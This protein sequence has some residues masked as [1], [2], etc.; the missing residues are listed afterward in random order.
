[1]SYFPYFQEKHQLLPP[2]IWAVIYYLVILS[3][4]LLS[5]WLFLPCCF[6]PIVAINNKDTFKFPFLQKLN[7]NN[8]RKLVYITVIYHK[9]LT[10]TT[11]LL[12][13]CMI[14]SA[15]MEPR[16]ISCADSA[17]MIFLNSA[18]FGIFP[19]LNSGDF[20]D[21]RLKSY[22][23]S[24]NVI[25]FGIYS[26]FALWKNICMHLQTP[27]NVCCNGECVFELGFVTSQS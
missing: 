22:I 14:N 21:F 8:L 2:F 11:E 15:S 23:P 26:F 7:L 24:E 12:F 6:D 1:M 3:H 27:R 5:L 25:V 13:R 18:V 10:L 19:S 16:V 9:S 4:F 20:Q 17:T